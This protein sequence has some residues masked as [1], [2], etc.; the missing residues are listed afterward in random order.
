MYKSLLWLG[1]AAFIFC[2]IFNNA[3]LKV[4]LSYVDSNIAYRG[5][6]LPLLI[7]QAVFSFVPLYV[8]FGVL[9]VAIINFGSNARA[10]IRIAF[11]SK[12]TEL[13]SMYLG[14]IIASKRIQSVMDPLITVLINTFALLVVFIAVSIYAKKKNTYMSVDKYTFSRKMLT[15]PYTRGAALMCGAYV[16]L[17]VIAEVISNVTYITNP[18]NYYNIPNDV[19][20]ILLEFGLPYMLVISLALLGFVIMLCVGLA[21]DKFKRSGKRKFIELNKNA[22]E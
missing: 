21:A 1:V 22:A 16:L 3:F 7:M 18:K 5:L 10:V 2:P 6:T 8:G 17:N 20:G 15:H 9:A 19:G 14:E 11:I 4:L 12:L 13:L